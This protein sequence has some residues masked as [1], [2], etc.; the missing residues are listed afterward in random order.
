MEPTRKTNAEL[1]RDCVEWLFNRIGHERGDYNDGFV[2]RRHA[3]PTKTMEEGDLP[4]FGEKKR[5]LKLRTARR[6]RQPGES[7]K[8][9]KR[10]KQ[11][12]EILVLLEKTDEMAE[13]GLTLDDVWD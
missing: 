13:R 3:D 8:G 1:V 11:F 12:L 9:N 6:S 5:M 4:A 2:V 10:Q 7:Y